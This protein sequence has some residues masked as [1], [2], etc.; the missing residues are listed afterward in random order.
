[1]TKLRAVLPSYLAS[2]KEKN[3]EGRKSFH[4]RIIRTMTASPRSSYA[5]SLGFL[6]AVILP[7]T[8]LAADPFEAVKNGRPVFH[9]ETF[10][11]GHTHSWGVFETRAGGP[12][13]LIH[14]WTTG[15]WD[16]KVLKFEQDLEIQG[17][18]RSHRSWEVRR[19]DE[20][21]YSATGTGIIG[22]ARG[23]TRGNAFHLEFTID[24]KPGN[25]LAH[26]HMSQWMYLQPDG[27]T[28]VNRDRLTK[29]G[30][31]VAEITEQF[32]K[33]R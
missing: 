15:Q 11:S 31:T 19:I 18:K 33:D 3:A 27:V 5:S 9:P 12:S 29:A 20:H 23:E 28:M 16:G 10:F 4:Q 26:L 8:G 14:T 6:L 1:M 21:H 17:S 30:I 22:T 7:A 24:A 32:H 25:P 13:K 2:G